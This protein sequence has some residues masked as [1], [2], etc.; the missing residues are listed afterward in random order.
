M[1]CQVRAAAC[2]TQSTYCNSRMHAAHVGYRCGSE[3]QRQQYLPDLTSMTTLASYCLTEPGSGSDAAS[4][5]ATARRDGDCYVLDGKHWCCFR[6][7]HGNACAVT[8]TSC[9]TA[10]AKAFIS[11][12]G[13]SD[14]YLVLARTGQP[15]P[16]GISAFLVRKVGCHLLDNLLPSCISHCKHSAQGTP[17][18]SLCCNFCL[19]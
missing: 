17:C 8:E 19:G 12:G 15:G 6:T 9:S 18:R 16:K 3:E 10:G 11:G 2:P 4:L 7:L 5:R 14:V 1:S 13:V